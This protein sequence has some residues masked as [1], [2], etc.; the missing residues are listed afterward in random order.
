MAGQ[1]LPARN[2]ACRLLTAMTALLVAL[3][4]HAAPLRITWD[5][6]RRLSENNP[7]IRASRHERAAA[8]AGVDAAGVAPNPEAE[9]SVG[10]GLAKDGSAAGVEWG[11]DVSMPLDWI[12][13]SGAES[14]AAVALARAAEAETDATHRAVLLRLRVLFWQLAYEQ[15]RVAALRELN[16]QTRTLA[17]TVER[18]V[19]RGEVRPVEAMRVRVEAETI[20]GEL[21]LAMA[22][23]DARRVELGLWLGVDAVE[24][25]TELSALPDAGELTDARGEHPAVR[26]AEARVRAAEAAVSKERLERVPAFGV[27]IFTEHEL[28]RHAYGAGVAVELPLWNWNTGRIEQAE[29]TAAAHESQLDAQRLEIEVATGNATAACRAGVA[30]ARRFRD[31][32]LPPAEDAARTA[33]RTYELGEASLLEVIDARRTLLATKQR[34]LESLVRAQIDCSRL[35][36]LTGEK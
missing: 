32:I 36:S 15:E 12:A 25:I 1:R 2:P 18:R 22:E 9:A 23:L 11:V 8:R 29:S 20:A 3:P 28:D 4:A 10:R 16:G 35:R 27:T 13:R 30:V 14:R 7:Q 17:A 6:V 26:A 34:L 31:N 33:E 24:A 5:D 19:Q 21:E